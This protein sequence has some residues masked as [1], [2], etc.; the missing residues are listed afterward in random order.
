MW[1]LLSQ[2][3]PA[4]LFP[5]ARSTGG[6][7]VLGGFCF[8]HDSLFLPLPSDHERALPRPRS[9]CM[10]WSALTTPAWAKVGRTNPNS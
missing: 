4:L 5:F 9:S 2:H 7:F 1:L 8:K 3:D 10:G 6:D